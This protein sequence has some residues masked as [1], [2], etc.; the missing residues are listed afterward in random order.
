MKPFLE[1]SEWGFWCVLRAGFT[2]LVS[3]FGL[4]FSVFWLLDIGRNRWM[5]RWRK[6]SCVPWKICEGVEKFFWFC[7]VMK[8][9]ILFIMPWVSCSSCH[10]SCFAWWFFVATA[11]NRK[12]MAL[13][14]AKS[15]AGI[16]V[17]LLWPSASA[18]NA[19][20]RFYKEMPLRNRTADG[21][22]VNNM[23]YIIIICLI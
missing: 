21:S 9:K 6:I 13:I 14:F 12:N 2:I 23:P 7:V 4:V 1:A 15:R 16:I 22:W 18:F 8:W 3:A 5:W 11:A 20:N 19:A 10:V 17:T